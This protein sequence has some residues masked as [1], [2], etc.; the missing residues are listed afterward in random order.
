MPAVADATRRY[1]F[2]LAFAL[3]LALAGVALVADAVAGPRICT[4]RDTLVFGNRTV[5]SSTSA[6]V[7]VTNC[8]DAPWSFTD[9]SVHPATGPAFQVST[10]C[11]TGATLGPGGACTLDVRFAPIVAGQTSGAVWL[12]NTTTTP[13]Q[14]V[15][16]YG[17]GV[18]EQSGSASLTFTPGNASFAAQVVGTRSPPL[19]VELRNH[20][21][22]ALTPAAIVLNGPHAY[23]FSGLNDTC[24]IGSAIAPG[25]ACRIALYFQP[26]AA[27]D[28]QANL[29]IDS[30][31][32]A[33]LATLQIT[34]IA[35]TTSTSIVEVI[36]FY[37]A[38]LDHYFVSSSAPDIDAL[39]SGRLPGWVRTG[40][41]FRAY[42]RP[43]PGA[44]PVCRFYIPP[45]HGDSHFLSADPEECA[46]VEQAIISDPYYSGY[47]YEAPDVFHIGLP[48]RA[49]GACAAGTRPVFRLWNQRADSNHRYT[50][51]PQ[52]KTLMQS[53]GYLTEGYGP[54]A[55]SMCAAP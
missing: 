4:S 32:L 34:G 55:T 41:I 39:D 14:L 22:A 28:R 47:V 30:A 51:D 45:Q 31:Q 5:G 38:A 53:R 1:R 37:H 2:R 8:G 16:F 33:S 12:R 54:D 43:A 17:R 21:P 18:D 42:A 26:R 29:V 46:R 9:V 48:D 44:S 23:D 20:G 10:T 36:E 24:Q 7:T 25:A 50:T 27:G 13:D 19:I 15:T 11:L 6:S 52:I 35:V 40:Q 49:T 3:A